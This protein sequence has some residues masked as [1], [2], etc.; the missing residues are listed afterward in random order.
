MKKKNL[1]LKD[2]SVGELE[3]EVQ[4]LREEIAK[5]KLEFRVNPAKDTNILM[6]KR[7]QLAVTLTLIGEK[8]ELEKINS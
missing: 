5:I 2:K 4:D 3:K 1:K 8:K 7:K 6:K